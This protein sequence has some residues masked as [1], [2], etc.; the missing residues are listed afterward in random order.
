LLASLPG[1]LLLQASV[2]FKIVFAAAADSDVAWLLQLF[3]FLES[4]SQ[5]HSQVKYII[6]SGTKNL[7]PAVDFFPSVV[8]YPF[9]WHSYCN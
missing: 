9:C 3:E 7:A 1:A 2:I 6:Q 8:G 5:I 4:C